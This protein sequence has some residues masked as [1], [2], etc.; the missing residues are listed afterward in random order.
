M[1][2]KG[3][4]TYVITRDVIIPAGTHLMAP[5]VK[6]SR[7]G[8]DWEGVIAIDSDHTGYFSIELGV[9]IDAGLVVELKPDDRQ[10]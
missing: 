3:F 5:P 10:S 6:S 9:A 4:K 8:N 1:S 2:R 7:W